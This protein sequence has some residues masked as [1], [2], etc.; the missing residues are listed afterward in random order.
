LSNNT[1]SRDGYGSNINFDMSQIIASRYQDKAA[2]LGIT[3]PSLA[4]TDYNPQ[5][6]ATYELVAR[7]IISDYY[8]ERVAPFNDLIP[9]RGTVV[10]NVSG[11]GDF[12]ES[13]LRASTPR[14]SVGGPRNLVDGSSDGSIGDRID[15]GA[16]SLGDRYETNTTRYGQRRQEFDEGREGSGGANDRFNERFYDR[17]QRQRNPLHRRLRGD[18]D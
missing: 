11:P 3:A 18:D 15:E 14:R 16:G 4:R 17:D 7:E 5:E 10:G 1:S 12:S 6:Q 2:E 13:D 9:E 8:D